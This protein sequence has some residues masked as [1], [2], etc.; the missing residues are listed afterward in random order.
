MGARNDVAA[1]GSDADR[2]E[3]EDDAREAE[4]KAMVANTAPPAPGAEEAGSDKRHMDPPVRPF[5][6]CHSRRG[7]ICA[8]A[9]R[10]ER[11]T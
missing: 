1:L 8:P 5:Q 4:P 3:E 11:T 7:G 9:V 2:A 10:V 6:T